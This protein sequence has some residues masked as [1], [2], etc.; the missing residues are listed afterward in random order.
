MISFGKAVVCSRLESSF[1]VCADRVFLRS[2]G[3]LWDISSETL[4]LVLQAEGLAGV[5]LDEA[6]KFSVFLSDG[7]YHL[8]NG[9]LVKSSMSMTQKE[10]VSENYGGVLYTVDRRGYPSVSHSLHDA[11]GELIFEIKDRYVIFLGCFCGDFLFYRRRE[12]ELFSVDAA[13]QKQKLYQSDDV[14]NIG[15][16]GNFVLISV[17][18]GEGK[19]RC[20][21]YDLNCKFLVDSHLVNFDGCGFFGV[22]EGADGW[23]F[24]WGNEFFLLRSNKVTRVFPNRKVLSYMF[25][26]GGAYVAFGDE[27]VLYF[28]DASLSRVQ[29]FLESPVKGFV[30]SMLEP[31]ENGFVCYLQQ[32]GKMT[33]LAYALFIN[34]SIKDGPVEISCEDRF[35]EYSKRLKSDSFGYVAN[36]VPGVRFDTLLRQAIA[37][38]D[39]AFSY[40]SENNVEALQFDGC[41]EVVMYT[42]ALSPEQRQAIEEACSQVAQRYFYCSSPVTGDVFNVKVI[43]IE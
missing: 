28:Y 34:K 33:G 37:A 1:N 25:S 5:G 19:A 40:F 4:D 38:V 10:Q 2:L 27:S 31:F 42:G 9:S 3:C 21:V 16:V 8:E 32:E 36:F 17:Q 12:K 43:F 24:L 41:V 13:G 7:V 6:G 15:R 26:G 30:F 22:S 11:A 18:L 29:F 14:T 39:E 35:F 20:D 23:G